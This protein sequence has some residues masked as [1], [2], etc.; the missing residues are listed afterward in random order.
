MWKCLSC[1]N[2]TFCIECDDNTYLYNGECIT[3]NG[4]MSAWGIVLIILSIA[5]VL[6]ALSSFG[7]MQFSR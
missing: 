4:G 7:L 6:G 3:N 2:T 5:I 1:I